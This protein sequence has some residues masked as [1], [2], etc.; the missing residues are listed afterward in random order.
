MIRKEYTH[1][2]IEEICNKILKILNDYYEEDD[3]FNPFFS[4]EK[5]LVDDLSNKNWLIFLS[6]GD[7]FSYQVPKKS[8]AHLLGIDTNYLAS[9]SM[10][11]K[12]MS[13]YDILKEFASSPSK[14]ENYSK[15]GIIDITRVISAYAIDKIDAFYNNINLDLNKVDFVCKYDKSRSY[16][17][18]D[19]GFNMDYMIVQEKDEKYYLLIL[20]KDENNSYLPVSNQ[21]FDSYEE[22]YNEISAKIPNQEIALMNGMHVKSKT[23]R[24]I[25][26]WMRSEDRVNKT[27]R[28]VNVSNDFDCI[29][30]VINDYIHSLGILNNNRQDDGYLQLMYEKMEKAI[31]KREPIDYGKL[32]ARY[33]NIP[34]YL[35]SIINS[36]NDSLFEGTDNTDKFSDLQLKNKN[37]Q[38][39]LNEA[40]KLKAELEAELNEV[41]G[42]YNDSQKINEELNDKIESIKKIL[43]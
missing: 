22:L 21:I 27:K 16:C 28:L 17:Y 39:K 33:E 30:N 2:Q 20:A 31:L 13:S 43:G 1:T 5:E 3:L 38:E 37:L 12:N 25:K 23:F 29:P 11:D 26:Y 15:K 14:M 9:T 42:K 10:F 6:N 36:Y 32:G 35:I 41:K 40:Y 24:P 19:D 8:L 4:N 7:N 18:T 34:E